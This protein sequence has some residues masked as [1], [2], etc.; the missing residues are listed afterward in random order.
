MELET[1]IA[2]FTEPDNVSGSTE[3]IGDTEAKD[4]KEIKECLTR[5][6]EQ[7]FL[8]CKELELLCTLSSRSTFVLI[9]ET[10]TLV[11]GMF[12]KI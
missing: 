5:L 1:L 4:C 6:I 11:L 8:T 10:S 3:G 9:S 2:D 12:E 7:S